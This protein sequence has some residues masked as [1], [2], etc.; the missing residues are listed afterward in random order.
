[1]NDIET[2][3]NLYEIKLVGERNFKIEVNLNL[4]QKNI[5]KIKN[6]T[7]LKEDSKLSENEN[8]LYGI[9]VKNLKEKLTSGRIDEETYEKVLETGRDVMQK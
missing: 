5:I 6:N 2:E 3:N 9:F 8:T 1:M 7:K 4:I